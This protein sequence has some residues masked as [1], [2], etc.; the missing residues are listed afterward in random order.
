MITVFV[1]GMADEA[2]DETYP[3]LQIVACSYR[4]PRLGNI[5]PLR[6]RRNET[7]HR[8]AYLLEG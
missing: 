8:T 6:P 4:T 1:L 2:R 5:S 3:T 7:A